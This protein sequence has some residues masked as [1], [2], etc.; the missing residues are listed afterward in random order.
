M[1]YLCGAF[2]LNAQR[3]YR[4]RVVTCVLMP[5]A[6]AGGEPERCPVNSAE[7]GDPAGS[8]GEAL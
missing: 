3:C 6:G 2:G 1:V 7:D 8:E 5:P 4:V